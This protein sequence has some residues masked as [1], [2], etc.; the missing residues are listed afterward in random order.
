MYAD[1]VPNFIT[2]TKDGLVGGA[3]FL[4][5]AP[6][7]GSA[8]GALAKCRSG[9]QPERCRS[10]RVRVSSRENAG[11]TERARLVLTCDHG[12]DSPRWLAEGLVDPEDLALTQRLA[13][14]L[15]AWV[16][17]IDA[18]FDVDRGW[19]SEEAKAKFEAVGDLLRDEVQAAVG[20]RFVVRTGYWW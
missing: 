20:D 1:G 16:I 17:A 8:I 12:A 14:R 6:D 2:A 19:R 5:R 4:A 10:P 13:E 11:M 7:T 3:L 9:T 18:D 15:R